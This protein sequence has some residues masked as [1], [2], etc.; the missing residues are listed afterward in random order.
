MVVVIIGSSIASKS[1]LQTLLP[2]LGNH[3]RV[4]IITRDRHLF[5]SRVML[6]NFIA[7][8]VGLAELGFAPE[9][10]LEDN[11]VKVINR[12]AKSI[13]TVSGKVRLDNGHEVGYDKL[14]ITSGASPANI[15]I[16]GTGLPGVFCLRDIEDAQSVK[17][18]AEKA[19]S[20]VVLG[21]GLI[22]LKAAMALKKSVKDV[23][24]VVGSSGL[25][26]MMADK[27][28]AGWIHDILNS[29]GIDIRLNTNAARIRG[30]GSGVRDIVFQDGTGINAD[31]VIIG[32]GVKPNTGLAE[33]TDIRVEKGIL[34]DS[35][36]KT[37]VENI[38]AA[39]DVAQAS[40]YIRG[41]TGLFTL[42]PDAAVQ[43]RIAAGN[44]LGTDRK[45][46]GGISMNSAVFYDIPFIMMGSV[47]EKDT[48]DCKVYE[49]FDRRKR[50]LRKVFVKD[51][52]LV[53]AV[54][55]GDISY[56]GMV[57][58]D[59]RSGRE[60]GRPQKYLT[61]EGLEKLFILRNKL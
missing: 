53:G 34:V 40:D 26:S 6:S 16:P 23:S 11:R 9:R 57:Y 13:D 17:A 7:G 32:K 46:T 52:R 42:W 47:R 38:Y 33:N 10:L 5:Y 30:D 28:S 19:G 48:K 8:E 20:C 35:R 4:V 39:G 3:D 56:A 55:A 22:S 2:G 18:W 59:I 1:A 61:N 24:I 21:G 36:M 12:E 29:N 51:G 45:Y 41:G 58:W 54:L 15:N 60:A 49:R 43:G 50:I 37:S 27:T 31:M 25:L 14:L 44:I